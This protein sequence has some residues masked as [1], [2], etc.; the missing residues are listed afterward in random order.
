MKDNYIHRREKEDNLF[1]RLQEETIK[2]LQELSGNVWTDYNLHDP[3]VTIAEILNYALYELQ[4]LLQFPFETYLASDGKIDFEKL[5]L[6]SKYILTEDSIVTVKDYENLIRKN[7]DGIM[8]CSVTLNEKNKYM[9]TVELDNDTDYDKTIN[10]IT[11]LYHSHRNLCETLEKVDVGKI[12]ISRGNRSAASSSPQFN[13]EAMPFNIKNNFPNEYY[14]VQNNFPDTYGL[15]EKGMSAG[16]TDEHEAKIMQLKAYMLIYD[17]LLAHTLHQAINANRILE[18]SGETVPAY[19]PGFKISK[20]KELTDDN[21][22]QNNKLQSKDFLALQKSHYLDFLDVIYGED[23]KSF[24]P[25]EDNITEQNRKRIE[26]IKKLTLLNANRNRSFNILDKDIDNNSPIQ[27]II[28]AIFGYNNNGKESIAEL[29][30]KYKLRLINDTEFFR[31]YDYLDTRHIIEYMESKSFDYKIEEVPEEKIVFEEY[32]FNDLESNLNFFWYNILFESF[33]YYGNSIGNYRIINNPET[34][35]YLLTF[36]IPNNKRWTN[37]GF[38]ADKSLLIRLA[39]QLQSFFNLLINSPGK[40]VYL[41]EH[42][43]LNLDDEEYNKLTIVIPDRGENDKIKE[44][45][46]SFISDRLPAYL[47]IHIVWLSFEKLYHF[48]ENYFLWRKAMADKDTDKARE[49]AEEVRGER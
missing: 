17:H 32:M 37:L 6:F 35:S 38:S 25:D 11:E 44:K 23:T 29:L 26:L 10:K 34:N 39:N 20:I 3:G 16:I 49:Y 27:R 47:D 48:E 18:L 28:S 41:I 1:S 15:N 12:N 5:G 31:D 33:L 43:L 19:K 40:T 9:I 30:S 36:G 2:E 4:Y 21:K 22:F 7:I 13:T 8:N 46:E 14:S 24:F 42:I 45:Y